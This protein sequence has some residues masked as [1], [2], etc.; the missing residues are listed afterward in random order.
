MINLFLSPRYSCV[1]VLG[2]RQTRSSFMQLRKLT[3]LA[4]K[5]MIELAVVVA[6]VGRRCAW[7]CIHRG[8]AM[9]GSSSPVHLVTIVNCD[10]KSVLNKTRSR[11]L[12]LQVMCSYHC[13]NVISR[14][15]RIGVIVSSRTSGGSTCLEYIQISHNTC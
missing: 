2:S 7:T 5:L 6:V 10:E 8:Q 15:I 12:A 3:C 14:A 1:C 4:A 9:L 11:N 13:T